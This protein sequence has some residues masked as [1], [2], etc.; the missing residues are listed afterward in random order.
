MVPQRLSHFKG[1]PE[2]FDSCLYGAW[3]EE[4]RE[5]EKEREVNPSNCGSGHRVTRWQTAEKRE[6]DWNPLKGRGNESVTLL[7]QSPSLACNK[8]RPGFS[9]KP[10]TRHLFALTRKLLW[11]E[12]QFTPSLLR[13]SSTESTHIWIYSGHF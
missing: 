13:Q 7:C 6:E 10:A 8:Q 5:E 3:W 9:S 11:P 4:R 1:L 12:F 2:Q